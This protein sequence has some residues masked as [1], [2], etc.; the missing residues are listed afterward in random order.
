MAKKKYEQVYSGIL[1]MPG[2]QMVSGDPHVQVNGVD[3]WTPQGDVT[4]IGAS[5]MSVINPLPNSALGNLGGVYVYSELSTVA[6]QNEDRSSIIRAFLTLDPVETPT[7]GEHGLW[8]GGR[9]RME[10]IVF[11]EGHGIDVDRWHPIYLNVGYRAFFAAG[12]FEMAALGML[13]YV[14]R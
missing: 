1:T 7:V 8:G 4:I 13:Y 3:L 6:R 9:D 2:V 10:Q 5:V 14:E 12:N 11:P